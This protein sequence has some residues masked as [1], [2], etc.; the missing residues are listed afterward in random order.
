MR[1][2][3]GRLKVVI[4]QRAADDASTAAQDLRVVAEVLEHGPF[5]FAQVR[6]GKFRFGHSPEFRSSNL[7]VGSPRTQ[8]RSRTDSGRIPIRRRDQLDHA[9]MQEAAGQR[10]RGEVLVYGFRVDAIRGDLAGAALRQFL[11]VIEH[12]VSGVQVAA[13]VAIV[14][15]AHGAVRSSR[16]VRVRE[17]RGEIYA[18]VTL[19]ECSPSDCTYK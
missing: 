11:A 16:S 2:Q 19:S 5:A 7:D 1:F 9:D 17:V 10:V 15:D 18:I 8:S 13:L 6:I 14:D 3:D 12:I 4:F